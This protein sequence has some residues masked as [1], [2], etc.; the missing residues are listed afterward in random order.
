MHLRLELRGRLLV[1]TLLAAGDSDAT[2]Q[3]EITQTYAPL[4]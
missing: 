1:P 2:S 3:H 4:Y